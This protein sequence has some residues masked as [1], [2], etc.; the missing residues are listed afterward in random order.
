MTVMLKMDELPDYIQQHGFLGYFHV[1][2]FFYV[3]TVSL[4]SR[5]NILNQILSHVQSGIHDKIRSLYSD[6]CGVYL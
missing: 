2:T 1:S 3:L 6:T 5:A 4:S